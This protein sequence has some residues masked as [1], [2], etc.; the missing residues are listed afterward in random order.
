[1]QEGAARIS[2]VS[3]LSFQASKKLV[4]AT[5]QQ[6]LALSMDVRQPQTIAAA[7]DEALREFKRIDILIN[8]EDGEGRVFS[9]TGIPGSTEEAEICV[10]RCGSSLVPLCCWVPRATS[11]SL[12]RAVSMCCPAWGHYP[13]P[14][15]S[16][17]V[18][19]TSPSPVLP[20]PVLQVL[21]GISCAQPVPC[22]S[23]PSRQ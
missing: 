23:T 21:Q 7:V 8:G 9:C 10:F 12:S 2:Q 18:P 16:Q 14:S 6:C 3:F 20:V 1:M 19:D 11:L 22:P 17:K 4:A 13:S 5:G 15:L